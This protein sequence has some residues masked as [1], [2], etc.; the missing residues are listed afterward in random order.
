AGSQKGA[1]TYDSSGGC[2]QPRPGAR[3]IKVGFISTYF[4][5]HTV[6]RLTQSLVANLSRDRLS[7]TVLLAAEQ[8][9]AMTD[10]FRQRADQFF[11]VPANLPAARRLIEDLELDVLLYTDVGMHAFTY[12]LAFSR[13]APVQCVTWG[14]PETTGLAT[15]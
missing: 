9:D 5:D 13:L 7:V 12:T 3:K 10:V 15:I 2:T 6:G 8:P 1:G 4:T 14:H 11:T